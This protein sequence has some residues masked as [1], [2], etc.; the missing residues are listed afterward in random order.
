M[1]QTRHLSAPSA[2]FPVW[3]VGRLRIAIILTVLILWELIAAS[4]LLYRDV[5]PSFVRIVAALG[6]LVGHLP[7]WLNLGVTA[8]EVFTALFIGGAAGLAAGITLG[9]VPILAAAFERYLIYLAPTPKIILFPVLI[10]AFGVGLGS[11]IAMGALSCFFPIAI[12]VATG[13]RQVD[14]GLIKVGKSFRLSSWQMLMKVYLPA[15]RIP[16]TNGIRL[17]FGV[18]IIGVLLSETKLSNQGLGYLIIQS[19]ARFDMPQMY[20]LLLIAFALAIAGN[21][22][23]S[24]VTR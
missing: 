4:G 23:F 16:T 12:S 6:E 11:K 20:A 22:L 1:A 19:Y 7:F 8:W 3:T 17:G 15:I 2:S 18:A 13:M 24:R 9:A 21:A 14:G 5:V 10:M